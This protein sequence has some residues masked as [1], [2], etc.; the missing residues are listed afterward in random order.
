MEHAT[1]SIQLPGVE[2][3]FVA[4]EVPQQTVSAC[5][6]YIQKTLIFTQRHTCWQGKASQR[7]WTNVL[8]LHIDEKDTS[9]Q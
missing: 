8:L 5:L 3:A 7:K 1:I 9:L 4:F 2:Y 6:T